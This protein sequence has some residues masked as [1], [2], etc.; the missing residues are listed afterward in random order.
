RYGNLSGT[1]RAC[2][3]RGRRCRDRLW[4]LLRWTQRDNLGCHLLLQRRKILCSLL[5]VGGGWALVLRNGARYGL[6]AAAHGLDGGGS[7]VCE[8]HVLR[9]ADELISPLFQRLQLVMQ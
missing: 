8:L 1:I 6:D 4:L 9:L 3:F 2:G 5:V 7:F